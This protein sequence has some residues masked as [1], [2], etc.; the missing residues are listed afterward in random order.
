MQP[1]LLLSIPVRDLGESDLGES[2]DFYVG[3]LG[4]RPGRVQGS[5]AD[6]WFFGMQVTLHERPDQVLVPEQTGVRHFG[7]T[8]AAGEMQALLARIEARGVVFASPVATDN[9]GVE[10]LTESALEGL[11]SQA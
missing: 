6:V 2:V 7:V 9:V 10:G 11:R 4:C 5:D 8:L 3:G 1:I